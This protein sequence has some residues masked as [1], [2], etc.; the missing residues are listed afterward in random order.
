[1][2]KEVRRDI[3]KMHAFRA[4]PRSG[5]GG[6]S[7]ALRRLV[8]AR[9]PHRPRR[10]AVLRAPLRGDALV[11]PDARA[12]RPLGRRADH[13]KPGATRASAPEGD[14]VEEVWKTVLRLHLQSRPPQ[15]RRDG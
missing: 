13:R 6:W 11:D 2:A 7:H 15:G 8:R 10:R 3:H 1:M 12:L 14:P 5:G 4:L 9:P